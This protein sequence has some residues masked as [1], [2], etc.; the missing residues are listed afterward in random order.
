MSSQNY[1]FLF[2]HIRSSETCVHVR[3]FPLCY[4]ERE[5]SRINHDAS[6]VGGEHLIGH[7][8]GQENHQMQG[9]HRIFLIARVP[10]CLFLD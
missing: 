2:S 5:V 9:R 6:S 10:S 7:Y 8:Y 4:L 3:L 1:G